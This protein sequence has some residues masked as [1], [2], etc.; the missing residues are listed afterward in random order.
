MLV[1]RLASVHRY[2]VKS[3][4]GELLDSAELGANGLLG[5]RAFAVRDDQAGEVRG[6]KKLPRLM[7]CS[8]RYDEEPSAARVPAAHI[9]LPDGTETS[10]DDPAVS[11]RVSAWLGRPAT[12]CPLRPASDKEHYRRVQPGSQVA[13]WLARSAPLRKVVSRLATVGPSGAELRRDFGREADEPL[14]DLS[15]FPAE[16]FEYVSPLG[17]Y[18]DAFPIHLLTTGTLATMRAKQPAGD[19]DA[20]RFRPNFV[21]ESLA[22]Q[23]ETPELGWAGKLLRIGEVVLECTVAT[24]RCSMVAQ[25]QPG[26]R[27]DPSVLR[28]IVRDADQ[29]LGLYARVKHGGRVASGAAVELIDEA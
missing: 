23:G 17:T 21:I 2:P 24:P 25:P 7:L 9:S 19:W 8:A 4:A 13:G 26:L 15:V 29:L 20:R 14:P 16:I 10:T 11:A 6:G 5:D 27:K 18:F 12:L 3:M 28:S 22:E 1:G